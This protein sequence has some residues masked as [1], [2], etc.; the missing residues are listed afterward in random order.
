MRNEDP[1]N[2][3]QLD[4]FS[5]AMSEGITP[6]DTEQE[7]EEEDEEETDDPDGAES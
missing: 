5:E 3:D 7:E 4:R 6:E 2:K 1:G